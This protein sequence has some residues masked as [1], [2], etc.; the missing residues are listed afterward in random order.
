MGTQAQET[1]QT[2]GAGTSIRTPLVAALLDAAVDGVVVTGPGQVICAVNRAGCLMFGYQESELLGRGLDALIAPAA[3]SAASSGVSSGNRVDRVDVSRVAPA[4][5]PATGRRH[6]GTAFPAVTNSRTARNDSGTLAVVVI[7]DVSDQVAA[8]ERASF[9]ATH[10]PLTGVL[11]RGAFFDT[12]NRL[13]AT[14]PE[15]GTQAVVLYSLD[16][17]QF[18]DINEAYGF[19]VGDAALKAMVSRMGEVLPKDT[20]I[21]RIAA[22]EFAALVRVMDTEAARTLADVLHDRLT[23]SIYADRNWVRLRLSIG[24]AVFD[25]TARRVEEINAKT[26]LALEA[27]QQNGGNGVC[28]Y[29]PEMAAAATRRMLLNMHLHH[30]AARGE[31]RIVYQP[32][33]DTHSGRVSAAE[34][35]LRW[36]HKDLGAVSPGEFIPVA[37]DSGHIIAMTDWVLEQVVAQ[38]ASWEQR[39]P[40]IALERVFVNISGLSFQRG[41]LVRRLSELL[42]PYPFLRGRV[43]L[44]ITEQAA[45]R[46]LKTAIRIINDLASIG[47]Q[48]AIDDFG[49]GYS[50]LSYVQQLPVSKLKIDR[51]FI[52]DVPDNI[53]NVALVRAAVGMAHGLG[54][55]VV[56]EGV[57]TE[58]QYAFLQAVGCDHVQGYL[59]GYPMAADAFA[60]LVATRNQMIQNDPGEP[61]SYI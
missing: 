45:V 9:L 42:A 20:L 48:T 2:D 12:C 39:I 23:A 5:G 35:L 15:D 44:E 13:L 30:A 7:R 26:K 47:V 25:R 52:T 19:H 29:T 46:D 49:S 41:N 38:L 36:W 54:L 24:G 43:G 50:S 27:A 59:F 10:D 17:D 34:A 51:M 6:D 31:L 1:A 53:R 8:E 55:S 57:E 33:I 18:S 60:E 40:E 58:E 16:I 32:I 37:E 11:S 22:D 21:G 28:F 14:N 3:S 4:G 56:A 61:M